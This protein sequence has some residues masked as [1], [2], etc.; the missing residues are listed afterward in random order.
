M[1]ACPLNGDAAA[2]VITAC[3]RKSPRTD[4]GG[5][6]ASAR[7]STSSKLRRRDHSLRIL[8]RVANARP[9]PVLL[10]ALRRL[11]YPVESRYL[12]RYAHTVWVVFEKM[13]SRD[14]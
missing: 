8:E 6:L 11:R 10:R 1:P 13:P 4:T 5:S 2:L 14:D 12:N 9:R 3:R 7:R